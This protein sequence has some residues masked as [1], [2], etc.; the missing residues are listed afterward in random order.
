MELAQHLGVRA[1]RV[2][3]AHGHR[4][5]GGE[6]EPN[7]VAVRLRCPGWGLVR[8]A[9]AGRQGRHQ[10][11]AGLGHGGGRRLVQVRAVLHAAYPGP[12]RRLDRA[13][14]VRV[15]HHPTA[16]QPV[17]LVDQ[18]VELGVGDLHVVHPAPAGQRTRGGHLDP[19]RVRAHHPPDHRTC[20]VRAVEHRVGHRRVAEEVH[21]PGT[22]VPVVT[23]AAGGAHLPQRHQHLGTLDP[24]ALDGDP[25][26]RVRA[27]GVPDR[28]DATAQQVGEDRHGRQHPCGTGQAVG[29]LDRLRHA[30]M[31][32]AV[33]ETRHQQ[34]IRAVHRLVRVQVPSHRGDPLA[35]QHDVGPGHLAG[36]GVEH[37]AAGQ[38]YAFRHQ[39]FAYASNSAS[40]TGS[41]LART[42]SRALVTCVSVTS[43]ASRDSRIAVRAA[44]RTSAEQ[45]AAE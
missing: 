36:A 39:D 18:R 42:D 8:S 28:G 13:G 10:P 31:G 43:V 29:V 26:P 7:R 24:A 21:R 11:G 5:P 34:G 19:V 44:S 2:V 12:R 3:G 35:R 9:L 15:G 25:H 37:R 27:P 14:A 22:H 38:Q 23:D 17:R 45:S 1:D 32:V 30:D 20:L 41:R 16:A 33:D 4:H 40:C 6:G